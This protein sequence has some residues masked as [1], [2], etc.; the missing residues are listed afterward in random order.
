MKIAG[1]ITLYDIPPQF[2][3]TLKQ[4][5]SLDNPMYKTLKRM[6]NKRALYACPQYFTYYREN[7]QDN[8][9]TVGRG[10]ERRI[11]DYVER[12]GIPLYTEERVTDSPSE[13]LS[14]S[15]VLRDYQHGVIEEILKENQGIVRLDTGFGK[16]ILALKLIEEL[17]QETIFIVPRTALLQQFREE[18]ARYLAVEV[19]VV[20]GA[21]CDVRPITVAS[22][23]TLVRQPDLVRKLHDR[24]GLQIIDECH[25]TVTQKS[26]KVV[27]AFQAK[28]RYGLTAT[29]RRTD[30]Q[31]PALEFMYGPILVDR[32]LPSAEPTVRMV[33]TNTDSYTA[34]QYAEIINKQVTDQRRNKKVA[35]IISEE[36]RKGRRVL[37]LTKRIEHFTQLQEDLLKGSKGELDPGRCLLLTSDAPAKERTKTLNGLRSGKYP[38]DAL[39]GTFSLLSTGVDIPS[40]DTIVL[41]G[42]LKSDVLAEQS[43]G[44]IL[45]IFKDK[46]EPLIIDIWD[47]GNRVLYRQGLERKKFYEQRK[48]SIDIR[49]GESRSF[50]DSRRS[51][52][53]RT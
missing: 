10:L 8:S 43:V 16:T 50:L 33:R 27:E 48:W 37:C 22:L 42:D 35:G 25:T 2:R 26:R 46:K 44:R 34:Y 5:L 53:S 18:A 17:G 19:G 6:G 7:K 15:I 47:T 28:H 38:F 11:R 49:Q 24:F 3:R 52:Y 45:R 39:F 31:G 12:S 32:K 41:A 36:I 14:S 21:K 40:L 29:A 13:P 51:V 30:E 1:E 9:L 23:Q 4:A 20:R